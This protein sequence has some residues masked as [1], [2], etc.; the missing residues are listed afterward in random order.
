M[1]RI[2]LSPPHLN[3]RERELVLQA[4]DS[5]WITTLGPH[6]DAFENL[7]CRR[8][9]FSYAAALA[10]GTA[11]LHL[12][13]VL[14]NVKAG[15]RVLCST[16]TFS[17]TA[18]AIRYCGASPV[19]I[20]CDAATWNIDP[21]LLEEELVE[22]SR[23]GQLPRA[24]IVVDL[25]GQSADYDPIRS[26][27]AEYRVPIVED[28]AEALGA[29]Y[30]GQ[31]VGSFGEMG[32]FSFNGNKI[33]TTSGGGMLVSARKDYI[34][35]A[36]FLATQARDP[37]PYYQ[38]SHIGYNYRLSNILA[39]IG[40][41]QLENLERKIARRKEINCFYRK[42]ISDIQGIEFMPIAPYGEPNFWLTCITVDPAQCKASN[43]Q[44]RIA[45]EKENIESRPVW[46]PMHLQ[47]VFR[48]C[49]ARGG[50]VSERLFAEGLCLPSGSG[51]TDQDL[52]R[53]VRVL[54]ELCA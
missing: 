3:G 48:A 53:V 44:I 51:M 43:E 8:I 33:I 45:L 42:A 22:G 24:L 19:F 4:Y 54:R 25:Y 20:D 12:A 36:R 14:L 26:L 2:Y 21:T 1:K 50:G 30:K 47:P 15:D 17:A 46:K 38:H 34:D 49:R 31:P 40:I 35:Q 10:S 41:G 27:C 39:A 37:V 5:N 13:L 23:H 52:E 29:R 7:I 18:N 6:V 28:A 11:A 32:V 9:G 16:L